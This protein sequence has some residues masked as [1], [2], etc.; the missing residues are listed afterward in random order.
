[1]I[2]WSFAEKQEK[3]RRKDINKHFIFEFLRVLCK[4]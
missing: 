2:I 4:E 1:M 3:N